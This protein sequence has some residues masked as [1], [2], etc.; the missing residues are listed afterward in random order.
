MTVTQG[1]LPEQITY[2]VSSFSREFKV[3]WE[4]SD[5]AIVNMPKANIAWPC[6]SESA[7]AIKT[8]TQWASNK[9]WDGT[10]HVTPEEPLVFTQENK[11]LVDVRI[12]GI[13][14]R[15]NGG[16]AYKVYIPA[17]NFPKEVEDKPLV[18]DLREDTLL[19]IMLHG[20]IDKGVLQYPVRFGIVG[21]AL[22]LIPSPSPIMDALAARNDT[23][24]LT[25]ISKKDFVIGRAYT[26]KA[27][28]NKYIY[29]GDYEHYEV[30]SSS[31]AGHE[32][33][34]HR[35]VYKTKYKLRKI[36]SQLW[37]EF[38]EYDKR[39]LQRVTIADLNEG[40]YF[41]LV[42]SKSVIKDIGETTI[43]G[44][45]TTNIAE[46]INARFKLQVDADGAPEVDYIGLRTLNRELPKGCPLEF[47]KKR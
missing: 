24:K 8:A 45:S 36:K 13:E 40:Y 11:D 27:G 10:K 3:T 23:R 46:M 21:T 7:S 4:D 20:G 43:E 17:H 34:N 35:S 9:Y 16:R 26:D 41:K 42:K 2:V 14:Y 37:Y 44:E 15:G 6:S 39:T 32:Y 30:E 47:I 22:K 38:N 31:N 33:V 18:F 29:L 12:L 5:E 28:E 19:F 1:Y 25:P